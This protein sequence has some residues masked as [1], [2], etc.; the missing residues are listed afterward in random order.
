MIVSSHDLPGDLAVFRAPLWLM[1]VTVLL[2]P[3][4]FMNKKDGLRP[5]NLRDFVS[6]KICLTLSSDALS[7]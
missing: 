4:P 5:L 3:H 7:I 1:I 2:P 6:G